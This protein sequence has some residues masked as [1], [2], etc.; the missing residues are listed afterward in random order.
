MYFFFNEFKNQTILKFSPFLQGA[1]KNNFNIK[2]G[3]LAIS[4]EEIEFFEDIYNDYREEFNN[5]NEENKIKKVLFGLETSWENG[6]SH[7]VLSKD[8][9]EI[10]YNVLQN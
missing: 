4:K 10:P 1:L 6:L 3:G 2:C 7:F 9:M 5:I 8:S